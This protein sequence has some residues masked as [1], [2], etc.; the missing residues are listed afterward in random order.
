MVRH[1]AA[2]ATGAMPRKPRKR[3]GF[4]SERRRCVRCRNMFDTTQKRRVSCSYCFKQ[5]TEFSR[6]YTEGRNRV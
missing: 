5:N 2:G 1:G 4:K 6:G 3:S